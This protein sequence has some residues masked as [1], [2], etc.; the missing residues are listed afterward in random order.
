V[1]IDEVQDYLSLPTDLA[2]ALSQTRGLGVGLVLAHQYRA[3]LPANLRAGI[4]ANA[5][6]KIIFGLN[7]TDAKDTAAM[8]ADEK[9]EALDFKL[10]P[11]F[12]VYANLQHH[13]KST[14]WMSGSTLPA[15]P[16]ITAA[17]EVKA[18]SQTR[19]GQN[20]E[21]AERE[22]L[23]MLGHGRTAN[24]KPDSNKKVNSANSAPIGRRKRNSDEEQN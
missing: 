7:A 23:D 17:V 20:A 14:G 15:P 13:G 22:F 8:A 2:D 19:Y 12:A 16:V 1:F 9:L 21:A 5:R 4:D 24:G 18:R 6:N 3:Q 10:L 11:R